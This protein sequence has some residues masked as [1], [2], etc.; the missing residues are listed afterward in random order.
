MK[1]EVKRN[2]DLDLGRALEKEHWR[3]TNQHLRLQLLS[4]VHV[5]GHIGSWMIGV[6]GDDGARSESGH[7]R[8][9][10]GIGHEGGIG[11]ASAP[12]G[13]VVNADESASLGILFNECFIKELDD[14][15]DVRLNLD[16]GGKADGLG[17]DSAKRAHYLL[18]IG[19][20]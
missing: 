1:V 14:L 19:H 11:S 15:D 7:G 3:F 4:N 9:G 2:D 6:G 18:S 10:P 16:C 8:R 5:E 20:C 12:D 17:V 13:N